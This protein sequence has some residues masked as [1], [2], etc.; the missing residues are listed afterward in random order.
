MFEFITNF[1]HESGYL[2]IM[3]LM[4]LENIFPPLPS[5]LILPFAGFEAAQGE[6]HPVGII[7]S[8]SIGALIG[9][10][11]WYKV[12]YAVGTEGLKKWARKYGRWLTLNPTQVEYVDKWFDRHGHK[13]VFFGRLLPTVRTLIS[14]PAGI[15]EMPLKQFLLFSGLGTFIWSSVLVLAGYFM[16]QNYEEISHYINP[17]SNIIFATIVVLYLYRVVTFKNNLE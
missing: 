4:F 15:T 1:I 3:L 17:V 8:G 7:I 11:V 9:L 6:L 10:W 12:G 16:G 5:E 13:A 14:V 2:G